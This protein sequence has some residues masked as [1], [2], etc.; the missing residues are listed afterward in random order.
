MKVIRRTD[1]I[2]FLIYIMFTFIGYFS[3][4]NTVIGTEEEKKY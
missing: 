1:A 3:I 2:S 4:P